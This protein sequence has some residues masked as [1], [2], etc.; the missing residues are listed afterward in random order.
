MR[1]LTLLLLVLLFLIPLGAR[2]A[3][4]ADSAALKT[5][6]EI[7]ATGRVVYQNPRGELVGVDNQTVILMEVANGPDLCEDG[8]V[9]YGITDQDG[10]FDFTGTYEPANFLCDP[11]P[12]VRIEIWKRGG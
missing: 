9:E 7:R 2:A 1:S 4:D 11:S 5:P 3:D 10:Y 8:P 12:D 6:I